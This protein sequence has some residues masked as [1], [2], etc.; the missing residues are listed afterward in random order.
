MV[1]YCSPE[2]HSWHIESLSGRPASGVQLK[3]P[4]GVFLEI[5]LFA[6]KLPEETGQNIMGPR[7]QWTM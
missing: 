6:R 1:L 4:L 2:F 5:L 3:R 7:P